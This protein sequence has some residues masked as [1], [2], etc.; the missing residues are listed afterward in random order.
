M[1]CGANLTKIKPILDEYQACYKDKCRW[2][3]SY[4]FTCRFVVFFLSIFD[5][6]VYGNIYMFQIIFL[7]IFGFHTA[8]QPYTAN[9]LNVVDAVLLLDL[10]LITF[11][12]GSTADVLFTGSASSY[13]FSFSSHAF[14]SLLFSCTLRFPSQEPRSGSTSYMRG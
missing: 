12:Y 3:A 2:V 1:R 5:F 9:W 8:V 7:L 14:I 10:T 6:G 13:T 11:L 4:Y